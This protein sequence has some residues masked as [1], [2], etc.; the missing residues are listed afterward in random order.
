MTHILFFLLGA[1]LTLR[2]PTQVGYCWSKIRPLAHRAW[3]WVRRYSP[4]P[5][6]PYV[7]KHGDGY[8]IVRVWFGK[9]QYFD[10][11]DNSWGPR[12]YR[13]G[14]FTTL[15]SA[16]AALPFSNRVGPP[17]VAEEEQPR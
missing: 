8:I 12:A 10:N 16:R 3:D 7:A 5:G 14:M 13:H 17:P 9:A 11:S 1:Y 4:F 6:K 15:E 2:Y